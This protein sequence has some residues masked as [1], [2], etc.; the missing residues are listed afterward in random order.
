VAFWLGQELQQLQARQ[1]QARQLQALQE[2]QQR[3][4]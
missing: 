1:L 4:Q 2:V 3:V